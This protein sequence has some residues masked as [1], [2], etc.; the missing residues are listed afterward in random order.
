[1]Q[2]NDGFRGIVSSHVVTG[3]KSDDRNSIN[4]EAQMAVNDTE[5]VASS[6][7]LPKAIEL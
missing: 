2:C 4:Q 1:M 5:S 6:N 3:Y 7:R